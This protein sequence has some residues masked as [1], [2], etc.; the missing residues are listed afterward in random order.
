MLKTGD[1]GESHI[2]STS[3]HIQT[4]C[5]KETC[6]FKRFSGTCPC[7]YFKFTHFKI[8]EPQPE[9]R[10]KLLTK[11]RIYLASLIVALESRSLHAVQYVILL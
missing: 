2:Q 1:K 4:C 5:I 6:T 11:I 9:P 7:H 3:S 8:S 10:L